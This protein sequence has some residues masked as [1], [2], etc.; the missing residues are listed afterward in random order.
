[1]FE[2]LVEYVANH[3]CASKSAKSD[4]SEISLGTVKRPRFIPLQ[5]VSREKVAYVEYE[6]PVKTSSNLHVFSSLHWRNASSELGRCVVT[7]LP[8]LDRHRN[9][10]RHIT[11]LINIDHRGPTS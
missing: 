2:D 6:E 4:K 10:G 3:G 1:M 8:K 5:R 9:K 11:N 7:L